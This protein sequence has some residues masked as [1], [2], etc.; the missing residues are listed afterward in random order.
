MRASEIISNLIKRIEQEKE[1]INAREAKL[2]T[3]LDILHMIKKNGYIEKKEE[4]IK[5]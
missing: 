1:F 4:E 3:L 5:I 2:E